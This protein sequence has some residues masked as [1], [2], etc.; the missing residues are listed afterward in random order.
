MVWMDRLFSL[1]YHAPKVAASASAKIIVVLTNVTPKLSVRDVPPGSELQD[2]GGDQ[3]AA[4]NVGRAGQADVERGV[5]EVGCGLTHGGG[6]DLDDPEEERNFGNFS[7]HLSVNS[8]GSSWLRR[9][10]HG[11]GR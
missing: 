6:H 5:E 11:E 10:G 1:A 3:Q 7:Q 8:G 4:D 2:Q 9:S